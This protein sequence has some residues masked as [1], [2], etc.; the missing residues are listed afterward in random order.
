MRRPVLVLA[1][2]LL[3][4]SAAIA[5]DEANF[6]ALRA[7]SDHLAYALLCVGPVGSEPLLAARQHMVGVMALYGMT[8]EAA[9]TQIAQIEDRVLQGAQGRSMREVMGPDVTIE[10]VT[11]AC[12]Q[13]LEETGDAAAQALAAAR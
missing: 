2:A 11:I 13:L 1:A 5:D 4:T 9:E 12:T 7:G 3:A 6:Q 10:D 8:G